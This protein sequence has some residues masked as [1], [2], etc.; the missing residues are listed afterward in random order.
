M[1]ERGSAAAASGFDTSRIWLAAAIVGIV[2]GG[3]L[4]LAGQEDAADIAWAITTVVGII[5]MLREVVT[6]LLR[7]RTRRR[8]DRAARHAGGLGAAG[9]PGGRRHR[10]DALHR[11]G[12]G[13]L[14]GPAR[15]PRAVGPVGTGAANRQSLR[16]R[17]SRHQADRR[18]GGG[19]PAHGQDRRG[20]ARRRRDA[21]RRRPRRVGAHRRIATGR[22]PDGRPRAVGRRERR[23]RLRPAGIDDGRGEHL[24]R[25]RA[26]GEGSRTG[27]GAVRPTGRPLR[28]DLHPGHAGDRG[29]RPGCSAGIPPV[30]SRCSWWRR[31]VR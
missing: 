28:H 24:R 25:D 4:Q 16:G 2:A 13:G 20:R 19:G 6:G 5:P 8:R 15:A 29:R 1:A 27:Q 22:T 9:V 10:P 11:R 7:R 14:R 31:R 12:P 17:R 21:G 18:G 23:S 30:P 3:V 26:S